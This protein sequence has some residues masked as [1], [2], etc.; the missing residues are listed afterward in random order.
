M[1]LAVQII[2]GMDFKGKKLKVEA[3][4]FEQKGDYDPTKKR[5]K[6]TARQKK[7]FMEQQEQ[8]VFYGIENTV[9]YS[10]TGLGYTGIRTYRTEN[11]SPAQKQLTVCF[12]Q[13]GIRIYRISCIPD[14]KS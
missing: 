14:S 8:C 3:A 11:S 4:H 1:D 9:N 10:Y 5:R 6:L 12:V 7:R 2:D 13:S